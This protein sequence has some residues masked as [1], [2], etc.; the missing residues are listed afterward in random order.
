MKRKMIVLFALSL[1]VSSLPK[2]SIAAQAVSSGNAATETEANQQKPSPPLRK[3]PLSPVQERE[4]MNRYLNE[5][6]PSTEPWTKN[7][8]GIFDRWKADGKEAT[9]SVKFSSAKC[10]Q[11]GCLVT[12]TYSDFGK[13]QSGSQSLAESDVFQNWPGTKYRSPAE[14]LK[15]GTVNV[16]WVLFRPAEK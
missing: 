10:F 12:A 5:S 14:V 2:T 15:D 16:M 8:D 3:S 11:R 7:A 9:A 1:G 6:G 13:Y 4:R